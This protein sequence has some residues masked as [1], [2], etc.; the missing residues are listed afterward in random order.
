M[1]KYILGFLLI[2]FASVV[3]VYLTVNNFVAQPANEF[4]AILKDNVVLITNRAGNSGATAFKVRLPSGRVGLL[5]NFHVCAINDRE[6]IYA[7]YTDGDKILTEPVARFKLH[8][9]CLLK[10]RA[11]EPVGLRL[12]DSTPI[13]GEQL[14]IYG[15]PRLQPITLTTGYMSDHITIELIWNFEDKCEGPDYR[16]VELDMLSQFLYGTRELCLRKFLSYHSSIPIQPG[17]SGS[18]VLN[19]RGEVVA[20][21]FAANGEG[22]SYLVPLAMIKEFL[23]DK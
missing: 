3:N 18:P 4:L 11:F 15:H 2:T 20:V 19:N 5:T 7:K 9:L 21:A 12:A 23:K 6:P 8:D 10:G 13:N 1:R 22:S 16:R 17:N 14:Y